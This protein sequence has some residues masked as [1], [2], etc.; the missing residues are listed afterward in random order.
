MLSMAPTHDTSNLRL[1]WGERIRALRKERDLSL[2]QVASQVG[3]DKGYLARIE[4]GQ[5]GHR[6]PSEDMRMRIAEVLGVREEDLFTYDETEVTCRPHA[7]SAAAPEKSR[8][9]ATSPTIPKSQDPS[10][11]PH[12][13]SPAGE[14]GGSADADGPTGPEGGHE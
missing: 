9:S 13:A 14:A 8:R 11:S 10:A 5:I 12:A 3:T 7:A 1:R 4:R 6:G 2:M